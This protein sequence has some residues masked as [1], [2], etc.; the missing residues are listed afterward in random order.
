MEIGSLTTEVG[1]DTHTHTLH[2]FRCDINIGLYVFY[3]QYVFS[4]WNQ[5]THRIQ[6]G[7][8]NSHIMFELKVDF[9]SGV[10]VLIQEKIGQLDHLCVLIKNSNGICD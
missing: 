8:F 6:I 7:V 1:L 10:S 9:K 3:T 4:N 2:D 5:F